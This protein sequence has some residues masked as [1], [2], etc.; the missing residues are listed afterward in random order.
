[1]LAPRMPMRVLSVLG[2]R[3]EAIKMAPVIRAIA[4]QPE[5]L[6][7][8]VCVTGQHRDM[9]DQIMRV[10]ELVP[11]VDLDI[12]RPGQVPSEVASRVLAAMP[13]VFRD[14]RPDLVLVQ[15]DTTTTAATA[16]A[17]FLHDIPVGHVEAGLRTDD[18]HQPFPEEMNRRLTSL[19]TALHFPPTARARDAL[20]REGVPADRIVLTGN[21]VIDA[22]L[23]SQRVDYKFSVPALAALDPTRRIVLVTLHRRESFGAPM[24]SVCAALLQVAARH[25]DLRF[26]LPVHRN[27]SVRDVVLPA[28]GGSPSFLLIEPLDY[29]EFIHLMA[30][31]SL[32][33]T[34]SGGVQ[35]EAPALDV[36]VLVTREVTERPEGVEVGAARLVGTDEARIVS[37]IDELLTDATA[38]RAMASAP[39]PYG[40][41]RASERIVTAM[42]KW[43]Q[44]SS[45]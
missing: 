15:G 5:R 26:V 44:T 38:Y 13:A 21:T 32:I 43:A 33:V 37:T 25:P 1:M 8:L 9:L 3:P 36:P 24:R 12:M 14:T 31:S 17:A 29:L 2:T 19:V 27:P 41:G 40:D 10:F 35:E 23:Q 7:S 11:D 6:T 45:A 34:D 28:L 18:I 22:L 39:N 4:S 30:R 20:L 42:L 16:M